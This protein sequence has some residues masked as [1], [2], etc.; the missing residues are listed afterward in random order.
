MEPEFYLAIEETWN[1]YMPYLIRLL[2]DLGLAQG[3]VRNTLEIFNKIKFSRQI[4]N[5]IQ[6]SRQGF[7]SAGRTEE[8]EQSNRLFDETAKLTILPPKKL[9]Q[10]GSMERGPH[11]VLSS[12]TN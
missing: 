8:V 11:H 3:E 6:F 4:F 5:K 2:Q 7:N 12:L 9:A 1:A 10:M